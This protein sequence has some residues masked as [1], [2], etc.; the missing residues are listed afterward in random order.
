MEKNEGLKVL[1]R[2]LVHLNICTYIEVFTAREANII[3]KYQKEAAALWDDY[4]SNEEGATYTCTP[5]VSNELC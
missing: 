5:V 2:S 1:H 4:E 3:V